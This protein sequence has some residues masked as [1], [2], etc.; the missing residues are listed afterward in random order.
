MSGVQRNEF[1]HRL[2][3][4]GGY[5]VIDQLPDDVRAA[6]SQ[7]GVRQEDLERI[8]GSDRVI[9]GAG[10][11]EQ[12]FR[13]IDRR[14]G[15][16][17]QRLATRDRSGELT[18][19]GRIYEGLGQVVDANRARAAAEGG[20]RFAGEPT[21]TAIQEGRG[22]LELGA[23]GESVRRVQQALAD[24]GFTTPA[25][26]TG[27][28]D[29]DT[30]R[31]VQR[32]QREVGLEP[33]GRVGT[34]T[35]GAL[36]ATAP[37]PGQALERR[38]EFDRLYSDG[39]M[40]ITVALGFDE[41]GTTPDAEREVL[42]GLRR[43]GY[44]PLNRNALSAEERTRLGLNDDRWDPNARYFHRR[45]HDDTTHRDVDAV[46]RMIVAPTDGLDG[47]GARESFRRALE[48][49]EVVIYGGHARYGTGP[50]FDQI[51]RGGGNFV[52]DGQGNRHGSPPPAGLRDVVDR[53]RTDLRTVRAR[54]DYQLLVF[55][56]CST[57]EYLPMLRDQRV[58]GRN[59]TNTDVIATT[60][61]TSSGTRG[62]HLVRF[63]EGLT[64]RES[65]NTLFAAQNAVERNFRASF[66]DTVGADRAR[67]TYT[68]SGFLGNDSNRRV[69]TP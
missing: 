9:R 54:P 57:E 8:A 10:E 46:V 18:A 66:G 43:E 25:G 6:L 4:R 38:A 61:P 37:P 39:R 13:E 56:G 20:R 40:D 53:D 15:R 47:R 23:S 11:F 67:A 51:D 14:D 3:D 59:S 41:H 33:D 17:D 55:N 63:L 22:T 12:L 36:A 62:A 1:V 49:D 28:Y 48:Q 26:V 29:E 35:L 21:L 44:R 42:S 7:V 2:A 45:F 24:C 34:E 31:A 32:F 19:A 30:V 60:I 68:E 5:V 16:I 69:R 27:T 64:R 65:N 50:D 52:I 58:F